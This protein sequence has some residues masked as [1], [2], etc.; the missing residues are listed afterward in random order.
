[1]AIIRLTHPFLTSACTYIQRQKRNYRER[2]GTLRRMY[3]AYFIFENGAPALVSGTR[4]KHWE[5]SWESERFVAKVT[6]IFASG[7]PFFSPAKMS[8]PVNVCEHHHGLTDDY[9]LPR[10][11]YRRKT[12]AKKG[13]NNFL[14]MIVFYHGSHDS[15]GSHGSHRGSHGS[16]ARTLVR[17]GYSSLI[18][19]SLR[20]R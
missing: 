19:D 12:L 3:R 7:E 9:L 15:Y 6:E 5:R 17:P 14:F 11:N 2:L 20:R 1:M 10:S 8:P 18:F 4:Q 16:L 13:N